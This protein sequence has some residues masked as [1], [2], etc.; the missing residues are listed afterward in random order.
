MKMVI[1]SRKS[2]FI[3]SV[4]SIR[5][6]L[7]HIVRQPIMTRSLQKKYDLNNQDNCGMEEH[8]FTP[9]TAE[10]Y[11]RPNETTIW[12]CGSM[13]GCYALPHGFQEK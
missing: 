7:A 13:S 5:S 6:Y 4:F 8:Q 10:P 2:D 3:M 9:W 1:L 12:Q 11:L